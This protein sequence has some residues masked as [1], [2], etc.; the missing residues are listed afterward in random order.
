MKRL[1]TL[2]LLAFAAFTTGTKAQ[3]ITCN[4]DFTFTVSGSTANFIPVT[5][6]DTLLSQHKW[7]FGDGSPFSTAVFP[8]HTYSAGGAYTVTHVYRRL[9]PNGTVACSDTVS[10]IIQISTTQPCNLQAFFTFWVDTA[11]TQANTV[12]FFNAT[13]NFQPGDSI[14]WTFGDGTSSTA[15]NPV[16][17]YAQPGVYTVCIRVSRP[18]AAGTPPCVSEVCKIVTITGVPCNLQAYFTWHADSLQFNKIHF[19]NASVNFQPGDSIRWTFGDGTSSLDVNPTH[20]YAQPGSYTVCLRV[21]RYTQPGTPPCVDV[22]CKLVIVQQPCNILANFIWRADS[23]QV[24]KIIFTNTTA[25]FQPGDSIRWTFGDGTSSFDVNPTHIYNQPGMYT[26]CLRVKRNSN[27]S[28]GVPCISE[29]CK[30]IVVQ[31]TCNLQANFTWR[32]D[33]TQSNKIWFTN[34]TVN[35]QPGDSIRWTFG[36]GTSSFDAN[37]MHVYT[38]SG[39]YTVCLRVKRNTIAGTPCVSEICK[40]IQVQV[41]CNIL[42]KFT[43]RADSLNPRKVYFT[44]NTLSPTA[45]ATATWSFGDGTSATSWNAVHE[46]ANYGTYIVCLTVKTSNTCIRTNCDTIVIAPPMPAC[47]NLS[48]F[49]A[50]KFSNDNQSYLFKPDYQNPALQYTWTF[51]DGTGSQSMIASHRYAQPGTYTVCLTVFKN[52]NCASTT[53]KTITVLPQVNCNNINVT[54]TYQRDAFMPNKV[55]FYAISNFPILQQKWTIT[56][57]PVNSNPSVVLFQNNPVY[58]FQDTGRYRVCL[59]AITLGGCIKETCQ[60]ITISQVAS[61]CQLQAYPNPA[62]SVVNVNVPLTQPEMIYAYVYN[63]QNILVKQKQQQGVTGN[64]VVSIGV[65]DL[66]SGQYTIK[67]IYGNKT[68]YAKFQKL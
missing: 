14:R 7:T 12:H 46:Y 11:A 44:N 34:T 55:Y 68:C 19:T 10:K 61:Q 49:T 38:Q 5:P 40:I 57:I 29:I 28:G 35:Y 13:V 59:R 58:V 22:I 6:G 41:P 16:H 66:V 37:P 21:S 52:N 67:L 18:T 15:L 17:T 27:V 45:G 64:N 3:I 24:N 65:G 42:V 20:V 2:L 60:E 63:S 62:T 33:S 56:R 53:C 36:D 51:G 23:V 43:W 54:F 47:N 30:I 48:K 1:F 31:S 26:V 32:P 4:A 8:S 39:S 25:N 9:T 50:T